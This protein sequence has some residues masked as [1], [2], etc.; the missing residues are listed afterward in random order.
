MAAAASKDIDLSAVEAVKL[1][2]SD[3]TEN[4][5]TSLSNLD[6]KG[7]KSLLGEKVVQALLKDSVAE[8]RAK[9]TPFVKSEPRVTNQAVSQ[10]QTEGKKGNARPAYEDFFK[11]TRGF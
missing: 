2:E 4:I 7:I 9:E 1:V 11:N 3:F 8:V 6:A 10:S 5:R